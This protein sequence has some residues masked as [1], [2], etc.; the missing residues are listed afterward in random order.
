MNINFKN[1][2]IKDIDLLL[3][4]MEKFYAIDNYNFDKK[5]TKDCLEEFIGNQILGRIW[6]IKK[7]DDAIGYVILTFS[8]SFE[9]HGKDAFLDE[10]YLEEEYRNQGIGSKTIEHI[11]VEA[12]KLGINSIHLETETH[13]EAGKKIYKKFNFKDH[14][15]ALMTRW[16]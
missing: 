15:R 12:K 2:K 14:R 5:I 4:Y 6:I 1:A 10:L 7:D 3:K 11:L 16:L 13:N 9:F 8:Y